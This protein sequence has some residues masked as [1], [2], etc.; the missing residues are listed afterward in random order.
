MGPIES[1]NSK[2]EFR[3]NR[4]INPVSIPTFHSIWTGRKQTFRGVYYPIDDSMIKT[5]TE[6]RFDD[7]NRKSTTPTDCSEKSSRPGPRIKVWLKVILKVT[8]DS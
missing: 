4:N 7:R 8:I 2:F 5:F 6:T 3:W 1:F